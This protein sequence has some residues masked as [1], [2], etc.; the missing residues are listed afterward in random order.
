MINLIRL[1][2]AASIG[3]GSGI[4]SNSLLFTFMSGGYLFLMHSLQGSFESAFQD[5]Y[6]I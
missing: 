5:E 3:S 2:P 4:N 6:Q 1:S